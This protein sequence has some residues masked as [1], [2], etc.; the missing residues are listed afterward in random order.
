MR[1]CASDATYESPKRH[2]DTHYRHMSCGGRRSDGV[3][4]QQRISVQH[5]AASTAACA[6][7]RSSHTDSIVH[8][9]STASLQPSESAE[10]PIGC[11]L[12]QQASTDSKDA[13][14]ARS[15]QLDGVPR[16]AHAY[17]AQHAEQLPGSGW[18]LRWAAALTFDSIASA[19]DD[20]GVQMLVFLTLFQL[21][22][23]RLGVAAVAPA[24]TSRNTE[25]SR[26]AEFDF[27]SSN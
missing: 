9:H 27:G 19:G 22:S 5:I 25:L 16:S 13:P 10:P 20:V 26:A 8:I 21:C 24:N 23:V 2:N 12:H 15:R 11:T 7:R 1:P 18:R 3:R 14:A 6:T 4:A 17:A